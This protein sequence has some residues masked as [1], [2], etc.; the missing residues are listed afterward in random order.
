MWALLGGSLAIVAGGVLL[1]ERVS[2]DASWT[3]LLPGFVVA[4]IGMGLANPTIAAAALRVVD[5]ARTGMASGISNTCRI[6][7]LAIGVAALGAFLQQRI[8]DRLAALG[9]HRRGFAEV[10]SAS[11]LRAARG[12]P[13]LA[14]AASVAFVSGFRL[15]LLIGCATVSAGALA[16]VLLARRRAAEA[17]APVPASTSS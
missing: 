9:V 11:G 10:V 5:P 7:G 1:M 15:V 17:P 14:H 2:V 8:G 13:E 4:G 3:V 6:G 12:H 16:A